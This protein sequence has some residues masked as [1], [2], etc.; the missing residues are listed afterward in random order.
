VRKRVL[1]VAFGIACCCALFSSDAPGGQREEAGLGA[2]EEKA[3]AVDISDVKAL[4]NRAKECEARGIDVENP[5]REE[6]ET[7]AEALFRHSQS[8]SFRAA[9]KEE[10]RRVREILSGVTGRE[11]GAA[12]EE[13]EGKA[14]NKETTK[15]QQPLLADNERIYVFIS[16]SVPMR[17][18]RNYA[19][20]IDRLGEKN[21]SFVMRG[22][23]GGMGTFGPTREFLRELVVDDPTCWTEDPGKC[24]GMN[25]QVSIDPM[26][27]RAFGVES[28]PAI[29]YEPGF[30]P[31]EPD[32]GLP[33]EVETG[34]SYMVCGD[35]S[36]TEALEVVNRVVK[37]KSLA[38]VLRR[39]GS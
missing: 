14:Q 19:R 38:G 1:A 31:A 2:R 32:H 29:A 15:G 34:D 9:V 7:Q 25:V 10:E 12:C 16:S 30:R 5:Y 39:L 18:L 35:A 21:I 17:T 22:F 8:D 27:F 6:T 33:F 26:L 36:I 28:V 37:A 11:Q 4:E 13:E 3:S 24:R 20:D 23:V